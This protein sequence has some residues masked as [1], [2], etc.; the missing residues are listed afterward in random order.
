MKTFQFVIAMR[1]VASNSPSIIIFGLFISLLIV[2]GG[3]SRLDIANQ[4][5]LQAASVAI[6]AFFILQHKSGNAVRSPIV[7]L[8]LVSMGLL[9]TVQLVPLPPFLWQN[10]PGR[11]MFA[12]TDAALQ[13]TTWR[14]LSIFPDATFSSALGLIPLTAVYLIL[15]RI[16]ASQWIKWNNLLILLIFVSLALGL[17]QM[18]S[19][20]KTLYFYKIS[21]FGSAVGFFANRNHQATIIALLPLLVT[22]YCV[23]GREKTKNSFSPIAMIVGAFVLTAASIFLSGSRLGL[24]LL[25]MVS[26]LSILL[27]FSFVPANNKIPDLYSRKRLLLTI[28]AAIGLAIAAASVVGMNSQGNA[29]SLDRVGTMELL[30]ETRFKVLP[31]VIEA[32]W[33]YF[34]VGAGFGTFDRAYR[35]QEPFDLLS[36]AYLNHA[37]NDLA[38]ILVEGGLPG[39]LILFSFLALFTRRGWDLWKGGRQR[40]DERSVLARTGWLVLLVILTAALFDYA[41]R[42]T[43]IATVAIIAACWAFPAQNTRV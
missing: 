18:L 17:L 35:I 11:S 21:N 16:G 32:G 25:G 34:P 20:G 19:V 33:R 26:I 23:V 39:L 36:L 14:P 4:G 6:V 3:S 22:A 29:T 8:L 31:T 42:T 41:L 13:I 12:A 37:H 30:N 24:V 2:L 5:V 38:E 15:T 27:L 9:F 10:L 43:A 40:V 1:N 28:T 7:A